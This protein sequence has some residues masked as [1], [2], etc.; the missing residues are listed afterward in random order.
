[1]D[2]ALPQEDPAARPLDIWLGVGLLLRLLVLLTALPFNADRHFEVIQFIAQHHALPTS[3]V[4]DTSYQPPRYYLLMLPFYLA[5]RG[6][7]LPHVA[8]FAISCA[9][10][11]LVR[12]AISEASVRVRVRVPLPAARV[13]AFALC[14]TLPQFAIYSG[15]LSN[16]SLAFLVGAGLFLAAIAYARMPTRDEP[17]QWW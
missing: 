2:E 14:A 1:M 11:G 10:L 17:L 13:V 12:R 9:T 16:D 15:F 5:T 3:N 4:I 8:T 7:K 6:P